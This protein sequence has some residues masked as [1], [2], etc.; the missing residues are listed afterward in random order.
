MLAHTFV[1]LLKSKLEDNI[2]KIESQI[3][4]KTEALENYNSLIKKV[5]DYKIKIKDMEL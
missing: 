2:N 1:E 3:K 4:N 5:S